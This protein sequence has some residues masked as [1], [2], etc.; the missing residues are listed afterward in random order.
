M[1][2]KLYLYPI[3][4]RIWHVLNALLFLTLVF[5]GLSL[6]YSSVDFSFIDFE[7]AVSMHNIAGIA[8]TLAYFMFV[9]G[10]LFTANGRFYKTK[11]KGFISD[12]IVQI[13]YYTFGIFKHQKTP[14]PVTAKRKFNPLQKFSYLGAMYVLLPILIASGL[15]LIFPEFIVKNVFGFSG[16]H[17]TG[18]VHIISG[19]SLSIFLFIHVYFCTIGKTP[20]SNFKSMYNGWH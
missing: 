4:L 14:Y 7:V 20:W 9:F 8:I 5:T 3:W 15:A 13:K 18:L 11:R 10:N 17:L 12:L 2:S 19:F 1:D 16:I 6:Q